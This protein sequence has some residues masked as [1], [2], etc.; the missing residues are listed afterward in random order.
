MQQKQQ[1]LTISNCSFDKL[2]SR[3][4]CNVLFGNEFQL[5]VCVCVYIYNLIW[6]E[7][8]AAVAFAENFTD[9]EAFAHL[10]FS[11]QF[12]SKKLTWTISCCNYEEVTLILISYYYYD[13]GQVSWKG[14]AVWSLCGTNQGKWSKF[15]LQGYKVNESSSEG[16]KIIKSSCESLSV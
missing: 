11:T 5:C 10:T 14:T 1:A 15:H 13:D 16:K 3:N 8:L 9:R 2:L 12:N 7:V 4:C 6:F